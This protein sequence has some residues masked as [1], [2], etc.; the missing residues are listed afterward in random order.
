MGEVLMLWRPRCLATHR[1]DDRRPQIIKAMCVRC[2]RVR[3]TLL[4]GRLRDRR[5][6]P[7]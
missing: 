1:H 4:F 2:C 6:P 7:C 3:Q 5:V